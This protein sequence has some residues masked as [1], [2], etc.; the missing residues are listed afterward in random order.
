MTCGSG[1]PTIARAKN[2]TAVTV[3][4]APLV[5]QTFWQGFGLNRDREFDLQQDE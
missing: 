1:R 4:A 5:R 3:G 2:L